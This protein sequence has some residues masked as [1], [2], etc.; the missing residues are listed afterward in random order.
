MDSNYLLPTREDTGVLTGTHFL[1]E[2]AI[3]PASIVGSVLFV[4]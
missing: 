2:A 4:A 3:I 1:F